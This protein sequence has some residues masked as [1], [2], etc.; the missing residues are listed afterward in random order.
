MKHG[1]ERRGM[2]SVRV[3]RPAEKLVVMVLVGEIDSVTAPKL[4]TCLHRELEHQPVALVLDLAGVSFLGVAGLPV[5]DCALARAKTLRVT[6]S[7]VYHNQS[8]VHGVLRTAALIGLFPNLPRPDAACEPVP[9]QRGS[10][11]LIPPITKPR[12]TQDA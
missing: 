9:R 12:L 5:L 6:V 8:A 4:S 10:G 2:F 11:Y 7:I 3:E 1:L